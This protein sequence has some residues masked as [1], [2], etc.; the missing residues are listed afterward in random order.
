MNPRSPFLMLVLTATLLACGSDP[1]RAQSPWRSLFNGRDLSGWV[2]VNT[3]PE[4][5]RVRDEMIVCT[6]R[7]R[8]ILRTERMYENFVLE[9]EWRHLEE[10]GNA[11]LF[12]SADA[13]PRRGAPYPES[14]E[15]QIKDGDHGSIFGIRGC[16]VRPLTNPRQKGRTGRA[17]PT[18]NRAHP[19]G[20]WNHYRLTSRDGTLE[21]A[22]NGKTVTRAADATQVKGY[23]CLEAEH[24]QVQFRNLQVKELPSSDPPADKV[25]DADEGFVSL[26]D[27]LSFDGWKVPDHLEGRW[28]AEDGVIR[29]RADQPPRQRGRDDHLWTERPFDDFIL[30]ADWRLTGEPV[31]RQ[32]NAFTEDGLIKR[33]EK[34][35]RVTHEVRHAG[36]SGIFLRGDRRAQVNIWCQPMGSGDIN[37]YHKDADLPTAVRR[38]CLP[39]T[40]ADHPPGRWNRFVITVRE[41][42]VSVVLNGQTVIEEAQLPG[43]ADRGPIGLQNHGDPIEFRNLFLKPLP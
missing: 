34:G 3:A 38:A 25:A 16:S 32:M 21:L 12:V 8:G 7:P 18:E 39:N 13:L 29:L 15:V 5:W 24:S 14:V 6:G 40:R 28:D 9:L 37:P 36:D 41:D 22:V 35:R 11:G 2:N 31:R 4:T 26:F 23:I 30:I 20:E 17:R 1:V 19:A 42:R 33:D 10:G 43:V 27:G